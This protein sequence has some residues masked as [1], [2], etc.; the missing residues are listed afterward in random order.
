MQAPTTGRL[1][2]VASGKGGVGKSTIA[3][4]IAWVLAQVMRNARIALV[5]GDPQAGATCALGLAPP[6]APLSAPP[7]CVAGITVS[8]SSRALA[9]ARAAELEQ[10]LCAVTAKAD[11]TVVDLSPALTDA[12]HAATLRSA[13]SV[14]VVAHC[15]AMG[16]PNVRELVEVLRLAKCR[17]LI[18]PTFSAPTRIARDA[19]RC[20]RDEFGPLVASTTVPLDTRAAEAPILHH[21]LPRYAPRS[22]AAVALRELV[23]ELLARHLVVGPVDAGASR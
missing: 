23:A 14:V 22:R 18:V 11:I 16:L 1:L 21:P 17:H 10:W 20:L 15:D 13:P 3:I 7:E 5:D 2:A 6:D 19:E 4:S 9:L 12:V 8:R